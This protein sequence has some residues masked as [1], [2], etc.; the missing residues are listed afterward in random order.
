MLLVDDDA[1]A[2]D[3]LRRS[4]ARDG[5]TVHE[6]ENGAIALERLDEER[7]SLILLDLMM[8]VMDGFAFLSRLRA[9]PDG[10]VPVVVLTAK[11]I[12][13]EERERLGRDTERVIVKGSVSLGEI[14]RHL[15]T[16]YA[17]QNQEPV[18]AALQGLI[19]ELEAR[20]GPP[21]G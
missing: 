7:P 20:A 18:P 8:P 19:D 9:R 15:R 4:L 2:R 10:D 11:D 16:I 3:R 1:D 6:A 14:G 21:G 17:V 5:W 13:P 12:T